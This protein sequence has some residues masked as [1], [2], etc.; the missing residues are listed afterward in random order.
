MLSEAQQF[1]DAIKGK[2]RQLI[3]SETD[4]TY[5]CERYEVTTV[6][7]GSKMG[8]TLPMG[9]NEIFLPYSRE[10]AR[11]TVG[12]PVIVVWW[13]S[14]SNAKVC[15]Y[16]NGFRG[17]VGTEWEYTVLL[18]STYGTLSMAVNQSASI[19]ILR[20]YGNGTS[21]PSGTRLNAS[22]APHKSYLQLLAAPIR[23]GD[24][25]V[26]ADSTGSADGYKVSVWLTTSAWSN[27][28]LAVPI[29]PEAL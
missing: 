24:Q 29:Y 1:W 13:K 12:T 14:M 22:I 23:N 17:N 18:D 16:A 2:V 6:A 7:D 20:W 4:N 27:G 15:Y 10:V 21:P 5:R 28:T 19:A 26:M 3:R 8:V 25:I 11:A 9:D